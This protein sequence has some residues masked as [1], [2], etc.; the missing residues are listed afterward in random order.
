MTDTIQILLTAVITTL[1]VLL[2]LIGVQIFI[3]LGEVR[4][5]LKKTNLMFDD[6]SKITH[7]VVQPVEEASSFVLGLKNGFGLIS[8][9]KKVFEAD[10]E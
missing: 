1:T 10:E 8:K 2:V 5:I 9:I 6:A 3:I 7:A 4:K